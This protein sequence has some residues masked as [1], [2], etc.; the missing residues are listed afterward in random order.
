M[1]IGTVDIPAVALFQPWRMY[2]SNSTFHIRLN[3]DPFGEVDCRLAYTSVDRYVVVGLR[4]TPQIHLE[5]SHAHLDMHSPQRQVAQVQPGLSRATVYIQ[6]HG[7]LVVEPQIPY[8][9]GCG[10]SG[11]GGLP[12]QQVSSQPARIV[13]NLGTQPQPIVSKPT[14]HQLIGSA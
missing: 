7:F 11:M 8:I 4:H 14:L 2:A 9:A 13:G 3:P 5:L 1:T 12:H 6:L 10:G